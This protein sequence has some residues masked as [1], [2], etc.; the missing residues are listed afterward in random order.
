MNQESYPVNDPLYGPIPLAKHEL[1]ILSTPQF[2]RLHHLK[3]L[4]FAFLALP[5]A[6]SSRFEHSIGV[7]RNA[8]LIIEHLSRNAE[9]SVSNEDR[10]VL[11]A[12][13]LLHDVGHGPF[14]H[15]FEKVLRLLG[16]KINQAHVSAEIIM[17]SKGLQKALESGHIDW[18]QVAA[19]IDPDEIKHLTGNHLLFARIIS[20]DVDADRIDYLLRDCFFAGLPQSI[21]ANRLINSLT[22]RK[23]RI[24][25][26]D[27]EELFLTE[28]GL[29]LA[30]ALLMARLS[31]RQHVWTNPENRA[32]ESLVFRAV[33]YAT[34]DGNT[35]SSLRGV[36]QDELA[37]KFRK[38]TDFDLLDELRR[39]GGLAAEILD[40]I[41]KG[42]MY[43]QKLRFR[44]PELNPEIKLQLS[45]TDRGDK[46]QQINQLRDMEHK[47]AEVI[48]KETG[49]SHNSVLVDFPELGSLQEIK[50]K[51]LLESG[52]Y[53][54]LSERSTFAATIGE[55]FRRYY[56]TH[57]FVLQ[58]PSAYT[59]KEQNAAVETI[60]RIMS[61]P[62]L[63]A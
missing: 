25:P 9:I 45:E 61:A 2:H 29:E 49:L 11:R 22:Y 21:D 47:Y 15:F 41:V 16:K 26:T 43:A 8:T 55:L 42:P 50:Q 54:L 27:I 57:V 60:R 63:R 18:K 7:L 30:D 14:S 20:G 5:S 35:D 46:L 17:E 23:I 10:Y 37:L 33:E 36:K 58:W 4:G 12:A 19:I 3:Q 38:W 24:Y 34:T 51:I 40:R 32:A 28:A 1:E 56:T 44:F 53:A 48:C 6:T 31:L 62:A 13:A 52:S 59:T 39:A